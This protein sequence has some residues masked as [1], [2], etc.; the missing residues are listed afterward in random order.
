MDL[1]VELACEKEKIDREFLRCGGKKKRLVAMHVAILGMEGDHISR[2]T[3]DNRRGNL[4]PCTNAENSKNRNLNRNNKSGFKGVYWHER[5]QR[6]MA[7][8]CADGKQID[9]GRFKTKEE[10]ARAYNEAANRLHG[11][12]ASPN[13]LGLEY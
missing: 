1:P 9:L 10:A 11:D 12:F 5:R 3:L 2:N 6:W 13:V 8:I 7:Q 4:R